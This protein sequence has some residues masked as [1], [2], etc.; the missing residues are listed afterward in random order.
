[1]KILISTLTEDQISMIWPYIESDVWQKKF[2]DYPA[3]VEYV[4]DILNQAGW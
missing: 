1:M 2:R 3:D 4:K